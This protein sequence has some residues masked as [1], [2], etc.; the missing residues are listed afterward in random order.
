MSTDLLQLARFWLYTQL[1]PSAGVC[2]FNATRPSKLQKL[3]I[4]APLS[5]MLKFGEVY[6]AP[7]TKLRSYA[8][9]KIFRTFEEF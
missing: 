6:C 1:S 7:E 5:F 3:K 9:K 8:C 2:I 4:Q